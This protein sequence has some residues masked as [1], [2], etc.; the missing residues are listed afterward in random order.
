MPTT[1]A[2]LFGFLARRAVAS[3]SIPEGVPQELRTVVDEVKE[4]CAEH[5]AAKSQ[6]TGDRCTATADGDG[7]AIEAEGIEI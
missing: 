1:T 3:I 7:D 2:D 6:P 4:A 5:P